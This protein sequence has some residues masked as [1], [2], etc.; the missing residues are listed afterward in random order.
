MTPQFTPPSAMA[1]DYQITC[2][3]GLRRLW[4]DSRQNREMDRQH[5]EKVPT[6]HLTRYDTDRGF[7]FVAFHDSQPLGPSTRG[8]P[9]DELPRYC[10]T[11]RCP[12]W[13]FWDP[14]TLSF[15]RT[16]TEGDQP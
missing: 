9:L 14:R 15:R 11:T 1:Q 16:E 10:E 4:M 7:R 12:A 8:V 3:N 5:A 6:T 13:Y 2:W